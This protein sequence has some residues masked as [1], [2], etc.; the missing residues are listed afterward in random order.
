MHSANKPTQCECDSDGS[1]RSILDGAA[2]DILKR[3]RGSLQV[4][5]CAARSVFSLAVQILSRA[6]SLVEDALYLALCIAGDAAEAL[7]DLTANVPGCASYSMFVHSVLP[8]GVENSQ[9]LNSAWHLPRQ[10]R[11]GMNCSK[12]FDG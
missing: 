8:F 10:A 11:R 5:G 4:I 3:G 7:F 9:A 1:I 12:D 2:N 6:L